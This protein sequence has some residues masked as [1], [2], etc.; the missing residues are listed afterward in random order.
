LVRALHNLP[1]LREIGFAAN[2]RL[3]VE[4]LSRDCLI[5]E[6]RFHTVTSPVVVDDQRA[7]ALRFRD[8]RVQARMH[9]LC[10]FALAPTGF[11]RR[12]VRAHGRRTAGPEGP[13]GSRGAMIYDLRRLRLHGLLERVAPQPPLSRRHTQCSG[14]DV[15]RPPLH[16]CA[17]PRLLATGPLGRGSVPFDRLDVALANFLQEV[18]LAA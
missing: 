15:S 10:L 9:A 14:G 11:R 5:G 17:T 1:A 2:R 12:D 3:H 6:D 18:K 13:H 7:A 8:R 4:S 16:G